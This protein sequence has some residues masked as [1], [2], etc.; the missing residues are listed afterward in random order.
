MRVG[1]SGAGRLRHTVFS[2]QNPLSKTDQAMQTNKES[3]A[4]C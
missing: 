1:L 2:K 3:T 4:R